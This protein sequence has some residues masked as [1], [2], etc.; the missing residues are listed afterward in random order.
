MEYDK[1]KFDELLE[2]EKRAYAHEMELIGK[3]LDHFKLTNEN[4][5]IDEMFARLDESDFEAM[6]RNVP[7]LG[8]F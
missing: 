7:V 4:E 3:D 2:R 5:S 8:V 6:R 1:Q